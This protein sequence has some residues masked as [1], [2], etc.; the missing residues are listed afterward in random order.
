[1]ENSWRI[2]LI[3][4]NSVMTNVIL[5]LTEKDNCRNRDMSDSKTLWN[6]QSA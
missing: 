1:M 5:I 4:K 2:D 6:K 3:T